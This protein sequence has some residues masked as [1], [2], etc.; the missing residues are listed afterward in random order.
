MKVR[1]SHSEARVA[2][3]KEG[4][5]VKTIDK[6]CAHCKKPYTASKS[7]LGVLRQRWCQDCRGP[8]GEGT[9]CL[10]QYDMSWPEY[11]AMRLEQQNS[12]AICKIDFATLSTKL[13]HIDHD[14]RTLR[15]RGIVCHRCNQRLATL[16]DEAWMN[17]GLQ[18]LEKIKQITETK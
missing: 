2:A 14:H 17:R 4:I 15:V 13:I 7:G 18:Y 16:D 11:T 3:H 10:K 1:R 6:M 12:C 8:N 5:Y 9:S